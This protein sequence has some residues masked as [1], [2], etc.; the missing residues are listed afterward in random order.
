MKVI[1]ERDEVWKRLRNNTKFKAE[2]R[3]QICNGTKRL[4][5]HHRTYERVGTP[6]EENDLVCLCSEC[7]FL[8]HRIKRR[9]WRAPANKKKP[10]LSIDEQRQRVDRKYRL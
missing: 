2:H 8:F 6:E 9:H 4:T 10:I 7:H 3:C 1:T 5:A